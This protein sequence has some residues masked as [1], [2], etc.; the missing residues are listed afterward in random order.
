MRILA[1]TGGHSFDRHAFSD[2]LD[3]LPGDITWREHP[4]ADIDLDEIAEF[5]VSLHYDM[6]GTLP[7]P[8]EPPPSL[9]A[10][11]RAAPR[12]GHGYVVLHHAIASWANWDEWSEF[13]GGRYLY[14]PGT[15]R[16]VPRPDSGYRH[17]VRQ[18]I[19]VENHAHPV[20]AGVPPQ[21]DLIDETYLCE[22]F[23]DSVVPLLRTDAPMTDDVHFST[24][25]AMAGRRDEREGWRHEPGSSLIGWCRARGRS[26]LVYLQPGDTAATLA[27]PHYRAL[28]ANSLRW[29]GHLA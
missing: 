5:D 7:E 4:D 24:A 3:A 6:P 19:T 26:R 25:L 10:R 12:S 11:L 28:V 2:F 17:A 16:G 18:R 15:V 20:V 21:F 27:S 14:R 29:A 9:Q 13:V 22:I 1:I 23:E 8:S